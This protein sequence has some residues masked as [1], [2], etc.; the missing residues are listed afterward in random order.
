M[1]QSLLTI[2]ASHASRNTPVSE[3][4]AALT[5]NNNFS[6]PIY[7]IGILYILTLLIIGK[8]CLLVIIVLVKIF[9]N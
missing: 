2:V 9:F 4:P 6:A 5:L 8:Y 3:T 1:T 7:G